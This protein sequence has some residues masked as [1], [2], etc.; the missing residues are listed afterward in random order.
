MAKLTLNK[1]VLHKESSKLKTYKRFLPALDLKR[2]QLMAEQKKNAKDLNKKQRDYDHLLQQVRRNLPMLAGNQVPLNDLVTVAEVEH[3][4]ENIVGIQ[5]P[6]LTKVRFHPPD[7]SFLGK[8]HWV[9]QLV[10]WLEQA[11]E[12]RLRIQNA[13]ERQ[14]ILDE[15][16]KK[17]TQRVN[18]FDKVLIPETQEN[19]RK[20]KIH[21]SDAERASVVRA[22]TAKSRKQA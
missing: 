20:I 2:R 13:N 10:E 16:V 3:S 4:R 14:Q 6:L 1:S 9:D 12:A 7:Y 11:I 19:I 18:L 15:A 8:P 5:L 21:L 22:K 17:I